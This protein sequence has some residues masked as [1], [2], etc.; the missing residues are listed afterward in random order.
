MADEGVRP[1]S[2]VEASSSHLTEKTIGAVTSSF[3]SRETSQAVQ[4]EKSVSRKAVILRKRS[5]KDLFVSG[6]GC[7][8][9][10]KINCC[11][12][13]FYNLY[14]LQCR[15]AETQ[16]VETQDAHQPHFVNKHLAQCFL[17]H[18][19]KLICQVNYHFWSKIRIFLFNHS[20]PL[21]CFKTSI[22]LVPVYKL[23]VFTLL[24]V[25]TS[26]PTG[27]GKRRRTLDLGQSS[28]SLSMLEQILSVS[29]SEGSDK[30]SWRSAIA[31]MS[32]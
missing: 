12:H 7:A 28:P 6:L 17:H 26:M 21:P 13:I 18:Y 29:E 14:S 16:T 4:V 22:T 3:V 25:F 11:K 10:V 5:N 15:E 9:I 30:D 2:S 24:P 23:F 8:S 1:S 27:L 20:G 32:G 19:P 31:E